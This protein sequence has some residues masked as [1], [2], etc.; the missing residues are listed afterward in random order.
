MPR[1]S[2]TAECS[3]DATVVR[4]TEQD[5]RA[6][7]RTACVS[8]VRRAARPPSVRPVHGHVRSGHVTVDEDPV[9]VVPQI[10]EARAQPLARRRACPSSAGSA[11]ARPTARR[12][13][14]PGGRGAATSGATEKPRGRARNVLETGNKAE[15]ESRAPATDAAARKSVRMNGGLGYVAGHGP[16]DGDWQLASGRVGAELTIDQAYDAA[17]ATGLSID[18][19]AGWIKVLGFVNAH[20]ASRRDARRDQR[21]QRPCCGALGRCWTPRALGDRCRRVT[22]G[23]AGRSRRDRRA[24]LRAARLGT[25]LRPGPRWAQGEHDQP[26]SQS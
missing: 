21:L 14:S 18:R 7:P 24:G 26:S 8:Q 23:H 6:S 19:V 5:A 17:R 11:S 4:E 1:S 2:R 12:R 3:D 15:P 25:L 13:C 10:A 16:F 9:D 20:G 22:V